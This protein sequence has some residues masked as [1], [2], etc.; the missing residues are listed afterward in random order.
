MIYMDSKI[1]EKDK[2]YHNTG[3]CPVC[4]GGIIAFRDSGIVVYKCGECNKVVLKE[5]A[6]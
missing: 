4:G 3:R 5:R 1:I 2:N 6:G